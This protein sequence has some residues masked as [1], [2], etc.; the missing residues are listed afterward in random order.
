MRAIM[1]LN[2]SSAIESSDSERRII[3]GKIVPY[4]KVGF[5]SAGPVVFAK[6]SIDIGDPGKINAYATQKRQAN[7]PHAKV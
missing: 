4:E 1:F 3:A 7:W 2:F 5:T 6:D